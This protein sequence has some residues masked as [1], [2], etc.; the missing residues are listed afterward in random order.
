MI[1]RKI[2]RK[3]LGQSASATFIALLTIVITV[4]LIRSIGQAANG[5]ID[6]QSVVNFL[7]F[8]TISYVPVVMVLTVF[9]SVLMVVSRAFRESEMAAWWAAGL[10]LTA[11][12]RP[13]LRFAL[14]MTVVAG[15]FSVF[16]TPWA[17]VQNMETMQRFQQRADISKVSAGQFRETSDGSRVY[18]IE[19]E[20]S[21]RRQVEQVFVL[22][23][24]AG[25]LTLVSSAGG[26]VRTEPNGERYLVLQEGT[27][28]DLQRTRNDFDVMNFESYGIRLEPGFYLPPDPTL[29]GRD[30]RL[31]LADSSGGAKG[32][33]LWRLGLPLSAIVL[34]LLAIPLSFVNPRA[35]NSLNLF[36]AL[37]IYFFYSNLLSIAQVWVSRDRA[38]FLVAFILPPLVGLLVFFWMMWRRNRVTYPSLFSRLKR[39]VTE[40]SWESA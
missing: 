35:G 33:L 27:R 40:K 16:L 11:W 18:F 3:E 31:L 25:K 26:V 13:V 21:D 8:S 1:F 20:S 19:R 6:N 24:K 12:V 29:Q 34:G 15:L 5:R 10:P 39:A 23:E 37:L 30:I 4:A 9:L 36:F 17:R 14:P 7:L 32:E 28:Y 38:G 2:I 22:T